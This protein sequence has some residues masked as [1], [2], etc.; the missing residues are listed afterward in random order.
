MNDID[1]TRRGRANEDVALADSDRVA[2][3][4]IVR[5]V[6]WLQ[7]HEHVSQRELAGLLDCDVSSVNRALIIEDTGPRGRRRDWRAHEVFRLALFFDL[8]VEVFYGTNVEEVWEERMAAAR[9][10]HNALLQSLDE[11]DD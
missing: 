1:V 8:P 6:R 9:T 10:E 5:T 3:A 11:D 2:H 7:E 4:R